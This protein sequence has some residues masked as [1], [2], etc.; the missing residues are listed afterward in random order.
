M[1]ENYS[2]K[3]EKETASYLSDPVDLCQHFDGFIIRKGKKKR[4]RWE[5]SDG[6]SKLCVR[7]LVDYRDAYHLKILRISR[8]TK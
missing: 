5:C 6:Q 7:E 1:V 3:K 2:L 8:I 4:M